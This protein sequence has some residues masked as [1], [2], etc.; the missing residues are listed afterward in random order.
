MIK[1]ELRKRLD[2]IGEIL[3]IFLSLE[4]FLLLSAHASG[5]FFFGT[6][7]LRRDLEQ[8]QSNPRQLLKIS[9]HITFDLALI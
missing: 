6:A 8:S 5:P 4:A 3:V 7:Y 1:V 9:T 2:F